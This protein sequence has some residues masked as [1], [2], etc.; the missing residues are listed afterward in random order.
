MADI[1]NSKT[2]KNPWYNAAKWQ[3]VK[4]AYNAKFPNGV[5]KF[6][7]F[8]A[9]VDALKGIIKDW[10]KVL[11]SGEAIYLLDIPNTI[12][13]RREDHPYP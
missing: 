1:P 5:P 2:P 9:K 3:Y 13:Q 6:P 4:Q 7:E 11:L 8:R 12:P 10:Q